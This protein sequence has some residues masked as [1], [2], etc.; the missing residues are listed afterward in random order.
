[1]YVTNSAA[2]Q[3]HTVTKKVEF[4][5]YRHF[6]LYRNLYMIALPKALTK[7]YV[8]D[9]DMLCS[10]NYIVCNMDNSAL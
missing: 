6:P 2:I 3:Y 9:V 1:M 10:A 5:I 4:L 8:T 7:A